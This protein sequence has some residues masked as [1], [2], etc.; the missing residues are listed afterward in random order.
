MYVS[1]GLG[2][3]IGIA[4]HT[5]RVPTAHGNGSSA[6]SNGQAKGKGK[7]TAAPSAPQEEQYLAQEVVEVLYDS[8]P[9]VN[10]PGGVA[11]IVQVGGF[12]VG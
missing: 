12:W 7:K 10:R 2:T 4:L 9:G 1:G 6:N 5:H 11:R 8:R 3:E